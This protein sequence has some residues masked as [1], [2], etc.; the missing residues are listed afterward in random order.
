MPGF[1]ATH[2]VSGYLHNAV[3]IF[4]SNVPLPLCAVKQLIDSKYFFCKS[5]VKFI[6]IDQACDGKNDCAGGEDEITCLSTFTVN[7]TF[8]GTPDAVT[9]C[10]QRHKDKAW[11]LIFFSFLLRPLLP[12]VRLTS[13]RHVLQVYNPG[14]GWRS[15]CRDDWTEQHTQ[16]ACKQ[17]G[18]TKWVDTHQG[19]IDCVAN[20]MSGLFEIEPY[21]VSL[22]FLQ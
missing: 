21:I 11:K 15:V 13:A 18:Y 8:P 2:C 20:L 3:L 12:P 4:V 7:T 17:L 9:L 22:L 10:H 16:T 6:P 14:Q 5:A 19:W 1:C